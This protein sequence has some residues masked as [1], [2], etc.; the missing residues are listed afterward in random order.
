VAFP[1]PEAGSGDCRIIFRDSGKGIPAP[2]LQRIFEPFVTTKEHGTGLG[3][4]V[5]RRIVEEHGGTISAAN[6][7]EGGGEFTVVLP[8]TVTGAELSDSPE[9]LLHPLLEP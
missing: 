4:A 3:L 9:L 6:H 5:S 2:A 7:P 1:A 8:L